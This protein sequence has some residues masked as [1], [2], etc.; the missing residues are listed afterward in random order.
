M[1]LSQNISKT[2]G[3]RVFG[4]GVASFGVLGLA[5]HD[6]VAGQDV[7]AGFPSRAALIT[8]VAVFLLV[9]G[10]TVLWR[11]TTAWAAAAIA[12]YFAIVV[13]GLM[14]GPGLLA[15]FKEY[16]PYEGIAEP[17]AIAAAGLIVFAMSAD[18]EAAL[19]ARLIRIGQIVFGICAVIFGGAHFAYMNLTAPLVPKWLPP[20]QVFW[21]FV[22]GV[23]Q[24]GA[25]L[26]ILTGIQAR[27]AAVLLT[28]MYALF[29]PLVF[30]PVLMADPSNHFRWGEAV[31]TLALAGVAWVM[32]DSRRERVS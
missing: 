19:A 4:L 17:L 8:V 21:G 32:A 9:A 1:A 14:D 2:F 28:V 3:W 11:R 26:A 23:C 7:P 5:L 6:F 30:V 10:G 24:M 16:G 13:A 22:T 29:I 25:G 12:A 18:I 27:L 31:A 20:S 15:D